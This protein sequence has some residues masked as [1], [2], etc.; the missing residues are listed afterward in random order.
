MSLANYTDLLASVATWLNRTDLTSVIPDF[1]T[2]AEERIARDLA[3]RWRDH[4]ASYAHARNQVC[5]CPECERAPIPF[6]AAVAG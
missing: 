6:G 5:W 2:L 4:C 3:E 1:V